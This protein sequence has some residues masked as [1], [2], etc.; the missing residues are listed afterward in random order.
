[1]KKIIISIYTFLYKLFYVFDGKVKLYGLSIW[2]SSIKRTKNTNVLLC[3]TTV[4]RSVFNV[5]GEGNAVSTEGAVMDS[6]EIRIS[7]TSNTVTI[8]SD[9]IIRNSVIVVNGNNCRITIGKSTRVGSMCMV[10]IGRDNYISVGPNCMIADN[11]D[12]WATD[13]HPIYDESGSI[14][15]P[16]QPIK[17][18][19]HVWLGKYSKVLKGVTIGENVIVG[20]NSIVTHDISAGSLVV[21]EQC[22]VVKNNV[23]WSRDFIEI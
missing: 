5:S 21:G 10:C 16:S 7:G 20:M 12:I 4:R 1:M 8:E 13:A 11:V 14:I 18:G 3:N 22:R 9:C 23:N 2:N 19:K 15:N 6:C 17:I